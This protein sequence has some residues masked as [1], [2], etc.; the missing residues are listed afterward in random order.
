MIVEAPSRRWPRYQMDLP[1]QVVLR[2]GAASVRVPGRVAEIS[3]GGMAL[4]A[5]I[6]LQPNE[7]VEVEFHTPANVRVTGIMRSRTGFLFGLEF[8][9][10][11]SA[12]DDSRPG[13]KLAFVG[14]GNG[15]SEAPRARVPKSNGQVPQQP[16]KPVQSAVALFR[17]THSACLRQKE[18]QMER[19][20][21]EIEALRRAAVVLEDAVQNTDAGQ[22]RPKDRINRR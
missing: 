18:L 10:P 13:P 15:A 2:D 22:N 14:R 6:H 20:R 19:L 5:G 12:H 4:Y 16:L 8:V 3:E 17:R 7:P 1:V 11:L 9:T 21:A